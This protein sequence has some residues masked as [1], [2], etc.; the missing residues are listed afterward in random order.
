MV[1]LFAGGYRMFGKVDRFFEEQSEKTEI[2]ESAKIEKIQTD[3]PCT[4]SLLSL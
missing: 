1:V 3:F 4:L 2:K